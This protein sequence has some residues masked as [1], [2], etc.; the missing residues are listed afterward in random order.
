MKRKVTLE[1]VQVNLQT[2]QVT[3]QTIQVALEVSLESISSQLLVVS[4]RI[5][6]LEQR[7][8]ALERRMDALEQRMDV[9]EQRMEAVE[10]HLSLHDKQ[11]ASLIERAVEHGELLRNLV[12]RDEFEV[13]K[14]R[15]AS[16]HDA[17]MRRLED[18]QKEFVSSKAGQ[19]RLEKRVDRAEANIHELQ[20]A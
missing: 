5:G 7:M 10:R 13:F 16:Q 20:A 11:I 6:V 3:L 8:E 12:T 9:L 14:D 1:T 2:V 17:M 18:L 4:Q 15:N 19:E